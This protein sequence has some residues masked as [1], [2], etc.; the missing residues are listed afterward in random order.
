MHTPFKYIVAK[1]TNP[2]F[3]YPVTKCPYFVLE[4]ECLRYTL[5]FGI[6]RV[7]FFTIRVSYHILNSVRNNDN[8]LF[9]RV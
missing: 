3:K 5:R 4:N 1:C 8:F 9:E 2:L 6:S 7:S